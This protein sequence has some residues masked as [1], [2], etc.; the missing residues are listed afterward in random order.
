MLIQRHADATPDAAAYY[1]MFTRHAR[2][3]LMPLKVFAALR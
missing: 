3:P 1:A 2:L